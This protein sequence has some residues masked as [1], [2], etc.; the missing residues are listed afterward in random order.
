MK[1][2]II[3]LLLSLVMLTSLL[4]PTALAEEEPSETVV[5]TVNYIYSS[6]SAM[7][8]QP[9][10]AQITKGESFQKTISAPS[11]ENYFVDLARSQGLTEDITYSGAACTVTFDVAAVNEDITVN[12]YYQAGQANYTVNHYQQNLENDEYTLVQDDTVQLTGDIDTYT[13]AVANKYDGFLC[14]GVPSY[15]I[16]ADGTT[17]VDIF[18]DR[19]YYTVVFDPNGGINGPTPVY[20]KYGQEFSVPEPP[21]RKG[22]TFVGWEPVMDNHITGDVTY[23]AQ[24]I[25]NEGNTNYT[26]VIWGQNANNDEYSYLSSH[27]AYGVPGETAT[28]DANAYICEGAHEHGAKCYTLTCGEE[29]HKHSAKCYK[30]TEHPH[31]SE[32]CALEEHRHGANCYPGGTTTQ[33]YPGF[34]PDDPENG[35]VYKRDYVLFSWSY[36][37]YNGS[38]YEYT[39][40]ASNGDVLT[41][42]CG[43]TAHTHG[44]GCQY[45]KC[46]QEAHKHNADCLICG[47][48]EEHTHT[49]YTVQN[50]C[51]TLTCSIAN[52]QHNAS[53]KKM[54]DCAPDSKLW[55]YERCEKVTID[56]DGSTVLNVYFKRVEFTL[57][58]RDGNSTVKTITER[59]GKD[60]SSYWPIVGNNGKQYNNGERWD[61]SGS[62]TYTEVLVYIAKMPAESFIL[63]CDRANSNPTYT[64][65]YYVE[66]LPGETGT[67][68]SGKTFKKAFEIKA[69]YNFVTKAEDFFEL[70][71]FTA[72][73]S[74]PEFKKGKI[75]NDYNTGKGYA[76]FYYTRN[77]YDLEF[78][79]GN[80]STPVKT[81]TPLYEENLG[82]YDFDPTQKPGTMEA[83]A[84]FVG[85]YLNPQCTGAE[86]VLK[87]HTMPANDIALYAKWVNGLYTVETFTDETLST[88]FTYDGYNGKQENIEKYTTAKALTQNP[89]KEGMSFVG[90][91]YKD[92]AG[93][94]QPFSFTMPIT[95]DY[96]LYPVFTDKAVVEY[97]VHYYLKGTTTKLADDRTNTAIVGTT[98]TEKAKMGT[99]LNLVPAADVNRYFPEVTSTSIQVDDLHREIIFYY[100]KDKTVPYTVRYVDPDGKD[101]IEPKVVSDNTYSVVTEIYVPIDNY[102]PRLFQITK[103]LS[104]TDTENNVII[105]IYDPN[106]TDLTIQKTGCDETIDENQ[107]FI[108]HVKGKDEKTKDV[109][110]KV[111][112]LG[113][114]KVTVKDLPVGLYEITE[115]QAWSWR[116]TTTN[117][118]HPTL[119][120]DASKNVFTFDNSRI[121]PLWLNGCSWAVNNWNNT[122][123]TK[124]PATPGSAN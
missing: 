30:D 105:F 7:V 112:I 48:Q 95:R 59:W 50:G 106:L 66:V 13:K 60:L 78:F 52:H 83:D 123:A 15:T 108:F 2:R 76:N 4:T 62:K 63:T 99:E 89:T 84:I 86:Y 114:G 26:I 58:F 23:K 65:T 11:I 90:W 72:W 92:E 118:Y 9:Y 43:K 41:M 17:V 27:E 111:T 14:T 70:E 121:R 103:E 102:T 124:S 10:R 20:G 82:K 40:D 97:V 79:S 109:D 56:A 68:Y 5:V 101:L 96:Q 21:T 8:A 120:V 104:W 1:K 74:D 47:Y 87:D 122:E 117:E 91:F 53:C 37:Y 44:N 98:V 77:T 39:G 113:N 19:L 55:K 81:N 115:E 67:S 25:A 93:N 22:Y 94:A 12:L 61:P 29:E 31:T 51:Y 107:S 116:Y 57:T 49:A 75:D 64:M 38:W 54:S 110:L 100:E 28:W 85:W 69:K 45:T 3:A 88:P 24:W 6:N 46:G 32:C 35:Q 16:A 71:G 34:A 119:N 42:N 18:Y 33:V 80:N 73:K 36:I